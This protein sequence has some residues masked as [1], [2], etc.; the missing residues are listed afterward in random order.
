MIDTGVAKTMANLELFPSDFWVHSNEQFQAANGESFGA[1]ILRHKIGIKFFPECIVWQHVYG[2]KLHGK[3]ILF[4]W[5]CYCKAQQLRLIPTGLRYKGYFQPFSLIT[6]IYAISDA[7]IRFD[8]IAN[9]LKLLCADSH[10]TFQ[11][12]SPLWKNEEF[13][14]KLPFKLN[15]DIFTAFKT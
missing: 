2:S 7:P 6:H 8:Y 4:G 14:V 9:K 11:H 5:D 15:E 1:T 12:P 10:A 3:D 13:F